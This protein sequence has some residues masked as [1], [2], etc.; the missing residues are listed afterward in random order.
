MMCEKI[1]IVDFEG[2]VERDDERL[3]TVWVTEKSVGGLG[4]D[5]TWVSSRTVLLSE[6]PNAPVL[7]LLKNAD[8][9]SNTLADI[10]RVADTGAHVYLLVEPDWGS[11]ESADELLRAPRVLVRRIDEVPV[12]ALLCASESYISLGGGFSLRLDSDQGGA[13]RQ[14]FLRLFWHGANSETWSG[15]QKVEWHPVNGRPF[16][17]PQARADAPIRWESADAKFR[18]CP[19]DALVH[20]ASGRLPDHRPR[21]MWFPAGPEHHDRLL[22]LINE[23]TEVVWTERGLPDIWVSA[24]RGEVLLLGVQGGLRVRLTEAQVSEV[25]LLLKTLSRWKF[26]KNLALKHLS[27]DS[28]CWLSGASKVSKRIDK[29]IIDVEDAVR[30]K[31][32]REFETTEPQILPDADPLA[33]TVTYR[34]TVEPPRVPKGARNDELVE[35]WT[36]LDEDWTA[37]LER[38]REALVTAEEDSSRIRQSF[39]R[40]ASDMLGFEHA[41][42]GLLERV[43]ALETRCP[44]EDGPTGAPAL[45]AQL[46]EVE[47]AARK[48]QTDLD[49][50]ERK[51][52]DDE[53]REK[54][55]AAWQGRVDAANRDLPDR[56]TALATAE[57][58][59][60]TIA[61]ELRRIEESLKSADKQTKKDLTANQRKLSDDLQRAKKDVTRLRGEIE[62]LGQQVGEQFEFR[63]PPAPKGRSTQ[64]AGR[65]VP[66]ASS[67]RPAVNVPEEALPKVGSLRSYK[68][69]RYL[70]ITTWEELDLGEK[71]ALRLSAELVA[72]EAS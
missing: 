4:L 61:D 19:S 63:Q 6:T 22:R 40:L 36:K 68:G 58:R 70:V 37:R 28:E 64:S 65:F 57:G 71:E 16:D 11:G 34:W 35:K 14:L 17:V 46:A 60:T 26:K 51:A 41:R 43:R 45:L 21:R 12:T 5:G 15:I 31:S 50:A 52:R 9:D 55:K 49:E 33:R 25:T 13:L 8:I 29:Q 20:I 47:G 44:S 69:Q 42:G 7:A 18:D 1:E 53:E 62:A 39:P 10:V 59:R 32:L 38:A 54:Q 3:S 72:P 30:A 67:A 2:K 66:S 24:S 27:V 56:R 23:G 48:L